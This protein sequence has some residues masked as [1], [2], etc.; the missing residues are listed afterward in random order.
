MYLDLRTLFSTVCH[1]K[2]LENL[3][4]LGPHRLQHVPRAARLS[5]EL[6]QRRI[7]LFQP[8]VLP[9]RAPP[10]FRS[11]V[12]NFY[13]LCGLAPPAFDFAYYCRASFRTQLRL[14]VHSCVS[15]FTAFSAP[16]S[17]GFRVFL[18]PHSPPICRLALVNLGANRPF[19]RPPFS[20]CLLHHDLAGSVSAF[21]LV[22][23]FSLRCSGT[24]WLVRGFLR[25]PSSHRS[26]KLL[27]YLLHCC[28]K[29]FLIRRSSG[30]SDCRIEFVIIFT[31]HFNFWKNLLPVPFRR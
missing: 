10:I 25:G 8:R 5:C 26:V 19:V 24:C 23:V 13:C 22:Q 15:V 6:L 14:S 28:R 11:R 21:L 16:C 27:P 18:Q 9:F 12:S 1:V 31:S 17:G 30:L 20:T 29:F 7:L 2:R 4:R 3:P